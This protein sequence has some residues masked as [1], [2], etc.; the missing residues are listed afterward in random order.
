M[1]GSY[2]LPLSCLSRFQQPSL[3]WNVK[4]S[5][6]RRGFWFV[7]EKRKGPSL[8]VTGPVR[9]T[10]SQL[11]L[12]L[13]GRRQCEGCC[14]KAQWEILWVCTGPRDRAVS[15]TVSGSVSLAGLAAHLSEIWPA[16]ELEPEH[17]GAVGHSVHI[18]TLCTDK[19]NNS[20][21]HFLCC[22]FFTFC[23]VPF[24]LHSRNET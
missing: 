15:F 3:Q 10:A 21:S 18:F 7:L 23:E 9:Q 11:D 14:Y 2:S 24:G 17:Q 1:E 5:S 22:C 16:A 4:L 12:T 20:Q 13:L 19:Q 8:T 6:A